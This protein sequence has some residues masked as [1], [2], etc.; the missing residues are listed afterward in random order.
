[1]KIESKE[2]ITIDIQD[3]DHSSGTRVRIEAAHS[4]VMNGNHLFY[5]PS[6]LESAAITANTF[7]KPLQKQHYDKTLGYIYK[8]NYNNFNTD[9]PYYKDIC[10]S[11]DFV[12]LTNTVK[13]YIK[14]DDYK[15]NSKGFGVLVSEAKLY[16]RSKIEDLKNG[17]SGTV[18]IAGKGTTVCS[19]CSQY[20]GKGGKCKHIL[21]NFYGKERCFGIVGNF[22]LDH[23]SF[24]AVP[25]NW[26]TNSS[27]MIADSQLQ[28]K[29]EL[30]KE[31]QPMTLDEL[32]E[33]VG[34]DISELTSSLGLGGYFIPKF[35]KETSTAKRSQFLLAKDR[36]LAVNTPLTTYVSK[37][38][39]DSLEDSEDKTMLLTLLEPKL[40]ATFADKT[41]EEILQALEEELKETPAEEAKE[42]ETEVVSEPTVV[43]EPVA[44]QP[45]VEVTD[46]DSMF[47]AISSRISDEVA[48]A[49]NSIVAAAKSDSDGEAN[50]LLLEQLEALQSD[51]NSA[52]VLIDQLNEDLRQSLIGQI[53][54]LKQ[55][56]LGSDYYDQIL[57]RSVPELKITL[58]D[59][60][61]MYN[62]VACETDIQDSLNTP[63]VQEEPE[64][65]DEPVVLEKT[66]TEE[67]L[68]TQEQDDPV[69]LEITDAD[70]HISGILEETTSTLSGAEFSKLYKN[71]VIS[72]GSV[73]AKKLRQALK[74]AKKI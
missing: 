44:E 4:G 24:E 39:V 34:S 31:G 57:T 49:V 60:T 16:N 26:E 64:V 41:S 38:L 40:K 68:V 36:M 12:S 54:L 53:L 61:A 74:A 27:I 3:K 8:T 23:I 65:K 51:L 20:M 2:N 71:T 1:M 33:K 9:S 46:A 35:L 28:G 21:G 58:Q 22:D 56:S 19:I 6:A 52:G 70:K 10:D 72:Y 29:L 15:Y 43:E 45:T 5:L 47:A 59:H 50:A 48:N 14:T 73:T 66:S 30:I 11:K 18:S 55:V 63:V 62:G 25:A 67:A 42:V 13:T 17:D 32:K 69:E 37:L 7:P